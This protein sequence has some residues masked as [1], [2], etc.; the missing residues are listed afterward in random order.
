MKTISALL[1]ACCFT[2]TVFGQQITLNGSLITDQ[3]APVPATRIS[4]AGFENTTDSKGQFKL[5]LSGDFS[6]GERVILKVI[7]PN[8]VINY[9]LDGEW[10][11][12]NIKLQNIQTLDVIIVPKGSKAL[13]THARIEKQI[14][15]MSDEIAR[16]KKEDDT[17]RPID[18]GFYLSEWAEQY[19]FTPEQVK[20]AFDEW[21]KAVEKSDDYR[22]LGLRAFYQNNFP[23]AAENFVNAAKKDEEHIKPI[24]EQLD[25]KVLSAYQNRKDAG[26]SL[27]N[28]YQFREALE[29]YTL[30]KLRLSELIAKEKHQREQA[31]VEVL[32]G[33]AKLQLGSRVEGK[34]ATLLLAESVDLYKRALDVFT[35]KQLPQD[36]ARTQHSLGIALNLQGARVAGAEG[37][38]LLAEAVGAFRNALLVRTLAELPQDWARTQHNLGGTLLRQGERTEGAQGAHLL[39]EAAKAYRAALSI[40]TSAKLPQDWAK[41]QNDL[42][43]VLQMQG[44]RTEGSEGLRLFAE[45][46]KAYRAA[47]SIRTRAKLPQD[48]AMT[49]NNLGNTLQ[50]QGELTKGV[51]GTPLLVESVN[52]YREALS[53]YTRDQLPQGW[54]MTQHNL[55][56]A[57]QS[58]GE[59]ADGALREKLL[60]EALQAFQLALQV[61]DRRYFPRDWAQTQ[62]NLASA[63]FALQ[64]WNNAAEC[65]ANVLTLFPDHGEAFER[66]AGLYHEVL[67]KFSAAFELNRRWL[68]MHPDDLVAATVFAGNHFTTGRFAECRARITALLAQPELAADIKLALRLIEIANLLALGQAQEVPVK[69]DLLSQAVAAQ[70]ADFKLTWTFNGT[71]HFIGQ[72]KK[73]APYREWLRQ[74]FNAAQAENRDAIIKGLREAKVGFK[75]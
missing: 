66:A 34:E 44:E 26:N 48:W 67:F 27:T 15:K 40:R 1:F 72:N 65:Y 49:Q 28:L 18:F 58:Q 45:A 6:E 70:P 8:W 30:A 59:R 21:A 38:D 43:I 12:P 42:G 20:A 4:V 35:R 32:I 10:N 36:W 3:K 33:D 7:K 50:S 16:L 17:P 5:V 13:W 69:L 37:V 9:P 14:A 24:Q 53:V 71:L 62:N 19:G 54:A 57:L 56:V 60:R 2:L 23:L 73:L 74:L 25:R 55:G 51:E 22:T 39:N 68:E 47:L 41:T 29:Q 64:D 75:W 63:Y 52:A 61:R 11:L 31:E 46:A